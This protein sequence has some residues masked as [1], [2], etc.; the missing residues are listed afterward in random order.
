MGM[1]LEQIAHE[2]ATDV[3]YCNPAL[4]EGDHTLHCT[5]ILAALRRV[6]A[7]AFERAEHIVMARA[8]QFRIDGWL[9]HAD[10][11]LR[12]AGAIARERAKRSGA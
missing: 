7:A 1:T 8:E 4:D 3:A 2:L 5:S 12:T 6:E 9:E 11:H 10:D